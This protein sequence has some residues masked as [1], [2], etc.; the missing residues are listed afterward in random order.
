MIA[1]YFDK[2]NHFLIDSIIYLTFFFRYTN[3]LMSILQ[4]KFIFYTE[5]KK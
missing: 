2:V 3:I 1:Q 5:C 4:K